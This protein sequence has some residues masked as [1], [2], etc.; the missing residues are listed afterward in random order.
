MDREDQE[1]EESEDQ[2]GEEREEE[3]RAPRCEPRGRRKFVLNATKSFTAP[4]IKG[5]F[6]CWNDCNPVQ[7]AGLD[8]AEF[9]LT[10]ACV[11]TAIAFACMIAMQ[12]G[13]IVVRLMYKRFCLLATSFAKVKGVAIVGLPTFFNLSSWLYAKLLTDRLR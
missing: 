6:V 5:S 12:L 4:R 3:G 10:S 1:G 9:S 2:E 7:P 13:I 8:A 11:Y